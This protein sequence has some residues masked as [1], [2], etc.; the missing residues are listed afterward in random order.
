MKAVF[1]TF[2]TAIESTQSSLAPYLALNQPRFDPEAIPARQRFLNR[3]LKLLRNLV[4]WRKYAGNK[5]G[6][7][8][9]AT[10]LLEECVL[11]VAESGWEVGG[12]ERVR[13]VRTSF[14]GLFFVLI[15]FF[16]KGGSDAPE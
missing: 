12:E 5:Y 3:R 13:K 6:L 4:A 7:D 1:L 15:G 9:L 16:Y 8:R 2:Q 10:T 11:P 14:I